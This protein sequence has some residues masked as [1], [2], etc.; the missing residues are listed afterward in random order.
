MKT[1]LANFVT[2][3]FCAGHNA[4]NHQ[5][6]N[7]IAKAIEFYLDGIGSRYEVELDNVKNTILNMQERA[8]Q[9]SRVIPPIDPLLS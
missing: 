6:L 1:P 4:I 8:L 7:D 2:C 5:A 9:Q 3:P